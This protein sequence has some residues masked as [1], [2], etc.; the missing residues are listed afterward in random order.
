MMVSP[1][2]ARLP[3]AMNLPH[4]AD[5]WGMGLVWIGG[6]SVGYI[7]ISSTGMGI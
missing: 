4:L 5:D 2:Y 1:S 7:G 3:L 6:F